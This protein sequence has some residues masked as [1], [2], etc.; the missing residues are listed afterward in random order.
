MAKNLSDKTSNPKS[1]KG[2]VANKLPG[3]NLKD[4]FGGFNSPSLGKTKGDVKADRHE[5]F[6]NADP[7]S[8][9]IAHLRLAWLF[10][11]SVVMNVVLLVA[12][13]I[14]IMG[15]ATLLPLKELRPIL[16]RD[17]TNEERIYTITPLEQD[18]RGFN[19]FLEQSAGRFVKWLLEID[20]ATQKLR[21]DQALP[22]M[23]ADFNRR[24]FK[25]HTDRIEAALNDNLIREIIIESTHEEEQRPGEWLITVDFKEIDRRD[26][27]I[28]SEDLLRAYVRLT[29]K[30][31]TVSVDELYSNP[32]GI[33]ILDMVVKTRGE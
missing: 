10:R 28:I 21:F 9:Q 4:F 2:L 8:F 6:R 22:F 17:H 16:L 7:F 1:K 32:L 18:V 33:I 12:F 5:S 3:F 15:Y 30:E 25:E 23:S 19:I 11:L 24:F 20:D 27:D 13:S 31:S 26:G 29:T 14:S